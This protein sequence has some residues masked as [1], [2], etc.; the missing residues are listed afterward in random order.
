[1]EFFIWLGVACTVPLAAAVAYSLSVSRAFGVVGRRFGLRRTGALTLEG[2][3]RGASLAVRRVFTSRRRR[4]GQVETLVE[5]KVGL[6]VGAGPHAGIPDI[7]SHHPDDC[8]PWMARRF[9]GLGDGSDTVQAVEVAAT[10]T[11]NDVE[12][13]R[14]L[15]FQ[16]IQIE[17]G[18]V[19][20]RFPRL[21]RS[22]RRLTERIEAVVAVA[23]LLAAGP[24]LP[25]RLLRVVRDVEDG[26]RSARALE[27]L[28]SLFPDS[29]E[30]RVALEEAPEHPQVMVR[31]M[32]GRFLP[33]ERAAP[34]L[35]SVF[36]ARSEPREV[37]AFALQVLAQRTEAE[38][39]K[40]HVLAALSDPEPL[41]QLTAWPFAGALKLV[42]ARPV[43]EANLRHGNDPLRLATVQA[44]ARMGE[45]G[46][47]DLLVRALEREWDELRLAALVALSELGTRDSLAA[48]QQLAAGRASRAVR[49]AAG[50]AAQAILARHPGVSGGLALAAVEGGG[51]AVAEADGGLS[52]AES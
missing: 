24:P 15:R 3:A 49:A 46:L 7:L 52:E 36:E 1:M 42:E 31:A 16:P 2:S 37:R 12:V 41:V 21:A 35:V 17:S 44:I 30:A 38:V 6:E 29:A 26:P 4:R 45:P 10:L 5:F 51:L 34:L 47:E 27:C 18:R 33:V 25:E 11:F 8:R 20:G 28:A 43:M 23:R 22:P 19:I 13:I 9:L 14:A 40:P 50:Q 39:C 48:V 32:A